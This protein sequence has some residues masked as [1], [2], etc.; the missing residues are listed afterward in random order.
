MV[1]LLCRELWFEE[2]LQILTE[3]INYPKR[4]LRPFYREENWGHEAMTW[5]RSLKL[6]FWRCWLRPLDLLMMLANPSASEAVHQRSVGISHKGWDCW[7][8]NKSKSSNGSRV[9]T[10][11]LSWALLSSAVSSLIKIC[12]V[13]FVLSSS[14]PPREKHVQWSIMFWK[15]AFFLQSFHIIFACNHFCRIVNVAS[16]LSGNSDPQKDVG[17]SFPLGRVRHLTA[18]RLWTYCYIFVKHRYVKQ[19]MLRSRK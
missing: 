6:H 15:A 2:M 7:M 19:E 5:W 13:L 14:T 4:E 18:Q 10:T 8:S 9:Q 16:P 1:A 17:K 3:S 12:H 11:S